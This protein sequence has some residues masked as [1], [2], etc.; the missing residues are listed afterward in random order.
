MFKF[1]NPGRLIDGEIELVLNNRVRGDSARGRVPYYKFKITYTNRREEIGLI[2]LRIGHTEHIEMY[3]GHIG[4]RVHPPFR[5]H[6]FAAKA[7]R[8]LY[9]L[10]RRH[11]LKR[12]WITCNP[13]NY[14]SRRTCELLGASLVDI[15]DIPKNNEMYLAGDRQKCRYR[16]DL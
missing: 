2:D 1:L 16:I 5:G 8:L 10:A 4:Y 3:A 7:C 14:A 13:D 11:G 9:P 15:V 6:H 12:L